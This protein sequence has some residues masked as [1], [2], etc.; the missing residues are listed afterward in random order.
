MRGRRRLSDGAIT[1]IALREPD[2]RKKI[3]SGR[4]G[5]RCQFIVHA[6]FVRPGFPSPTRSRWCLPRVIFSHLTP[7][8]LAFLLALWHRAATLLLHSHGFL[9][10]A[11]NRGSNSCRGAKKLSLEPEPMS[12]TAAA[13]YTPQPIHNL[14]SPAGCCSVALRIG[15]EQPQGSLRF[16]STI[17]ANPVQTTPES[18]A[19]T[20]GHPTRPNAGVNG[21]IGSSVF[22]SREIWV[23]RR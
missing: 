3:G 2:V 9:G 22:R 1:G 8:C 7:R 15:R 19:P 14:D 11:V 10:A 21:C 16:A 6:V 20:A 12:A 5:R 4:G 18:T 23:N 17:R 13:S